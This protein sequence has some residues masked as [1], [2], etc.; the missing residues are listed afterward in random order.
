MHLAKYAAGL[1]LLTASSVVE[2]DIVSGLQIVSEPG[3]FVGGGQTLMQDVDS[4]HLVTFPIDGL[5]IGNFP[6]TDSE[7]FWT[8][9]LTSPKPSTRLTVGCYEHARRDVLFEFA[10]PGL[11]FGFDHRGCNQTLGRYRIRELVANESTQQIERLAVDFVQHC[12]GAAP[13]LFGKLRVNSSIPMDTAPI[14]RAF[15]TSGHLS[16]ISPPSEPLGNGQNFLM[17]FDERSFQAWNERS[18][19]APPASLLAIKFSDELRNPSDWSLKLVR[20]DGL[21]LIPGSY[22]DA[23]DATSGDPSMPGMSFSLNGNSCGADLRGQFDIVEHERDRIDGLSTRLSMTL[24][25]SCSIMDAPLQA[26]LDYTTTFINGPLADDV[27]FL[28][29]VDPYQSWPLVWNCP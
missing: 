10:R 6:T 28:D 19:V 25:Q 29:G 13:A 24:S 14:E 21:P 16:V 1:L 18:L 20:Q 11:D 22:V 23:R 8:L 26:E 12:E 3:D 5:S 27:V 4:A 2:A 7:S 15:S 17:A 9:T